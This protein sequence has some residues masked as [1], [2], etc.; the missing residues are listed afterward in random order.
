MTREQLDEFARRLQMLSD[1]GVERIYE[2]TYREW[3]FK[4]HILPPAADIQQLVATWKVLRKFR[5]MSG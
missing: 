1:D 2:E 4:E 5:A 3:A